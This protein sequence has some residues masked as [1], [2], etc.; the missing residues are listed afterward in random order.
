MEEAARALNDANVA[1]YAVDGRGLIG[2]LG[3]MTGIQ[4]AE[5]GPQQTSPAMRNRAVGPAGP[6]HIETMNLPAGLTGG[7]VYFNT[8]GIEES[9]EKAVEDG[10]V[11]YSL[12]FYPAEDAQDGR[13]HRLSVK[14]ARAGVSLRYRENYF[15]TKPGSEAEN[16]PSLEQLLS[17]PLD[18]TQIGLAAHAAPD[19]GRPG[20]FNVEVAVDLHDVRLGNQDG[21]WVGAIEVSFRLE[22][23]KSFQ[24]MTRPIEIPEDQLSTALEKGIVV[25]HSIEWQG[26][27]TDV[28]VVVE[29]KGTGAAGSLRIP[30]GKK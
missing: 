10:D 17:D 6:T 16:R 19:G 5:F 11:T 7:D 24:V 28:R 23:S 25:A 2:A 29:D 14:V 13:V 4:N 21:K 8:N 18:A 30:L 26:K 22:D 9:I 27:P 15:A 20:V 1:L 3:Q 12:G